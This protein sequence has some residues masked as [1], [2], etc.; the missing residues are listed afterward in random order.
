MRFS[1]IDG[2]YL[3]KKVL[4]IALVMGIAALTVT[5][6]GC[7][8]ISNPLSRPSP[9]P[10]VVYGPI[11]PTPIPTPAVQASAT[12]SVV[13]TNSQ[14]SSA[15]KLIFPA[16]DSKV[17]SWDR[18]LNGQ[19]ENITLYVANDD[20]KPVENIVIWV[21]MT[22]NVKGVSVLYEDF[23]VG[24]LARGERKLVYLNTPSHEDINFAKVKFKVTWGKNNEYYNDIEQA[25]YLTA[26]V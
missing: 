13:V 9:T 26:Y 18:D 2:G 25:H 23:P 21:S 7:I 3:V 6:C 11:S 5:A 4:I 15:V 14:P 19:M 20:I 22:D 16:L 17:F 24:D 10:Y 1:Y 12:P 8:D